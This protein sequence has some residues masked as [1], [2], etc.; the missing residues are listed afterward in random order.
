MP[1]AWDGCGYPAPTVMSTL[2][3]TSTS[4]SRSAP[5]LSVFLPDGTLVADT[6]DEL[7]QAIASLY[8]AAFNSDGDGGGFDS[9]SPNKGPEPESVVVGRAEGVDLA[10]L[11][12]ER[13]GGVAVY[14]MTTPSDPVLGRVRQPDAR[15]LRP[16]G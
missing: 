14:D 8:P 3:A 4:S 5:G 9:R 12:L 16:A 10:F 13:I 11:G 6:G 7:E 15:F 1:R 2:T